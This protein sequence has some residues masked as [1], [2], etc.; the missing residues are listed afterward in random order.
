MRRKLAAT[1]LLLAATLPAYAQDE[2]RPDILFISI[3]DLNDWVGVLGGHPQAITPNI[4]ALAARGLTFTNAHT[5]AAICNPSRTALM[6]GLLPS[7]TGIYEND[8]SWL[9]HE[10][11]A[12][13]P[14][15]PRHF[16]EAGYRTLGAGKVFHSHTYF[17]G[18]FAGYN[19]P[20]AWDNF[21]PSFERQL[22]DEV[23]PP[24]RL[25]PVNENPFTSSF[26]WSVVVADDQAMGDGQVARWSAEQVLA[27][28]DDPRF[29][30]VG[31]YRP[32]P[33]WYVPQRYFDLYRLEEIV[34]P[35]APPSDLDDVSDVSYDF[36]QTGFMPPMEIHQWAVEENKWA[37][38]VQAYLASVS[39][40]DAMVGQVIDALDRSGRADN[41]IVVLWSDHGW[42]LGEKLRWRKHTLWEE[43]T[44]VPLIVVAPGVT[45]AGSRSSRAVSLLD[46]F[47][48]LAELAGIE[49]PE[50]LEGTSLVPLLMNPDAEWN[51]P[52]ISTHHFGNHAARSERYRYIRYHDG[53]EE[54]YDHDT[55]PNEWHNLADD[56]D[57]ADVKS[58]LAAW[59]PTDNA[60]D[61]RFADEQ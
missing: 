59:L 5:V 8:P 15:I 22:P 33:P 24:M 37:E 32:H 35:T 19:D 54:L 47:P 16:R 3:D 29:V 42:H 26:D 21:Y 11:L 34:L 53:S 46:L 39:F 58:E 2:D 38:G 7:T 20:R 6:L 4:D 61:L 1:A 23:T 9:D 45:T 52:A 12:N 49:A 18:A 41:T 40:A 43:S 10:H 56:P 28:G 14:T 30:A 17:P 36:A 50:N 55:D 51:R 25:L 60:P 57:Y 27:P 44:R 48:T 13:L 31:I